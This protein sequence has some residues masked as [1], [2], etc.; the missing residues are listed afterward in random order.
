MLQW[1]HRFTSVETQPPSLAD[2][3]DA[4]ASMGPPIY[5]GGNSEPDEEWLRKH[6][7]SMGPPIYIGGNDLIVQQAVQSRFASMGP[8]I[9]IGG[10]STDTPT[11]TD[12]HTRFN[13]ATD[14]HRWKRLW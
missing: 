1:G 11:T 12:D 14:L 13:G 5:I 10:N 9:Y 4:L 7:A 2:E 6:V 8:P 3:V